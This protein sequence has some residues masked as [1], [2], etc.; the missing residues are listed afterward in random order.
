MSGYRDQM[1]MASHW[2]GVP[3]SSC[4]C[5]YNRHVRIDALIDAIGLLEHERDR[6]RQAGATPG[7]AW[8]TAISILRTS[9]REL[10]WVE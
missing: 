4:L 6:R 5:E 3:D 10:G 7:P 1:C 9:L 8:T 2:D